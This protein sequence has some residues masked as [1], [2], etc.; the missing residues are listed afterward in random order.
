MALAHNPRIVTNGLVLALD[1]V[2]PKGNR[3]LSNSLAQWPW[4]LGTGSEIGFGRNG[5]EEENNRV[6]DTNPF[7][8]QDIVWQSP[9]N[10]IES[11]ADG[12][13]NT[14]N[15]AINPTKMYRFSTWVRKKSVMG[16][17][18]YYLGLYGEDV[19][20]TNIGVL[21]RYDA[22]SSTTNHY[23]HAPRFDTDL[24]SV[25]SINEWVLGVGHVWPEGSGTGS[26]HQD[27][28]I[29]NLSGNKIYSGGSG[30]AIWKPGTVEGRHR[31]YQFYST[32][33][34]E[35]Q[36]WWHPRVD[37]VD[38]TEPS[39]QQLLK[40]VGAN[41]SLIDNTKFNFNGS[42]WDNSSFKFN[43]TS[44]YID[45]PDDLGYDNEVSAFA[46]FKKVGTPAG[47]YH[48]IFGGQQLEISV[49]TSGLLRTGVYTNARY[50]SNHGT[51]LVDGNWHYIGFTFDGSTKKSYINGEYVGEQSVSGTL[52]NTF[53][54]R[55]MGR[56]G[57]SGT[58]YANGDIPVAKIYNRA[59]TEAEIKQN[60]N[61]AKGRYGL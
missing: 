57:S 29:W 60:F 25:V 30:D 42:H 24:S 41:W 58:Y 4:K 27:S 54:F 22:N 46:W 5:T 53:S 28:G 32:T 23:F 12:G 50:V 44:D 26:Q 6:I 3:Y 47:G 18:R 61:A 48:I 36:Q 13:W 40:G 11:N 17:G 51:G 38:G 55:R 14:N 2:N 43:G 21:R 20:S 59:L 45:L 10:D 15:F 31:S 9:G 1:A 37:V 7:G 39:I 35:I 34:N 16:N 33:T 8:G 19:N 52:T 49:P 56:Y